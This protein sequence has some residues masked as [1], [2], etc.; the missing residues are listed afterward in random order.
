MSSRQ[1]LDLAVDAVLEVQTIR[2]RSQTSANSAA[3]AL[4]KALRLER[5]SLVRE[6][7]GAHPAVLGRCGV[8]IPV[9]GGGLESVPQLEFFDDEC[10]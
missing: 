3:D 7:C 4:Q 6:L 2:R 9:P 8:P 10:L 1:Q 5:L